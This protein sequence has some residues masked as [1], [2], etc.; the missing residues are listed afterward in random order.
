[1]NATIQVTLVEVVTCVKLNKVWF[2]LKYGTQVKNIEENNQYKFLYSIFSQK[3][4]HMTG[5]MSGDSE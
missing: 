5:Q 4:I 2:G 1:M 3:I